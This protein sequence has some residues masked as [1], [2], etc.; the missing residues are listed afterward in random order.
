MESVKLMDE[1]AHA[2][3]GRKSRM[4]RVIYR[5]VD[6]TLRNSEVD[7]LQED[8]LDAIRLHMK[9]LELRIKPERRNS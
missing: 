8:V 3:T 6:R 9:H 5:A 2:E 7:K 1:F 4:Y